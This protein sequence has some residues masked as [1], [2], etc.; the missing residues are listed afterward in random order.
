M[1]ISFKDRVS[2]FVMSLDPPGLKRMKSDEQVHFIKRFHTSFHNFFSPI[3]IK[4]S[5]CFKG[6][7]LSH[8]L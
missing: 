1:R 6:Y 4:F 8:G 3:S 7:F 5:H 2:S